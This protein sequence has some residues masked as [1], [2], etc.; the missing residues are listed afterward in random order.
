[1]DT[2][3]LVVD[4]ETVSEAPIQDVAVTTQQV[5]QSKMTTAQMAEQIKEIDSKI[6]LNNAEVL[7][8]LATIPQIKASARAP[9]ASAANAEAENASKSMWSNL[10]DIGGKVTGAVKGV[11]GDVYSGVSASDVGKSVGAVY[12]YMMGKTLSI[13]KKGWFK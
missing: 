11:V 10:Y 2:K 1:M 4:G 8:V 5:E 7:R 3:S 6:G 9:N 12:D 13:S